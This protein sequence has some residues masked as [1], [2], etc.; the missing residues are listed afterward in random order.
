[1]EEALDLSFDRLLMMIIIIIIILLSVKMVHAT[2][3]I[4]TILSLGTELNA[5]QLLYDTTMGQVKTIQSV[6]YN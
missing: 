2:P 3:N 6:K 5:L 1:M 4:C